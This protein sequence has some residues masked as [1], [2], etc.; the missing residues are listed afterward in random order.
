MYRKL[1]DQRPPSD[2]GVW[3]DVIGKEGSPTLRFFGITTKSKDNFA[4]P[5]FEEY[6]K[7]GNTELLPPDV[8][9]KF[10]FKGKETELPT[11]AARKLEQY[12]GEERK[13]LA[14]PYVNDMAVLRG[15]KKK[16]SKLNPQEK[17]DALGIIYD[18]GYDQGLQRFQNKFPQYAEYKMTKSEKREEKRNQ[19]KKK[20]FRK[21]VD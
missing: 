10:T 18:V 8:K 19:R 13:K 14:S 4:Q 5:I 21:S 17:V 7:T 2:I 16:F 1:T 12:V 3:G 9:N 6:R 11:D 15:F 20:L